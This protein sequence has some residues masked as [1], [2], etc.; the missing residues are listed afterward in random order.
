MNVAYDANDLAGGFLELRSNALAD[1]DLLA[2][3]IFFRPELLRHALVDKDYAGRAGHITVGEVAPA[4]NG[5]FEN[6][7]VAGRGVHPAGVRLL[8][9][10]HRPP[11]NN[12][13][14]IKTAL[15]W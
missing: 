2:D 13:W 14:Q 1:D 15:Q 10:V 8:R 12:K 4:Q 6:I 9:F 7:E 3:R 5:N 11:D